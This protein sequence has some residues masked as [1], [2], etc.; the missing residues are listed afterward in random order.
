[1]GGDVLEVGIQGSPQKIRL[2]PSKPW[3]LGNPDP[4][5]ADLQAYNFCCRL[6]QLP[7]PSRLA[8]NKVVP[9]ML[10]CSDMC[11]WPILV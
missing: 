1:M 2:R 3:T 11:T 5:L 7:L 9:Q 6:D 4:F 10:L 8:R